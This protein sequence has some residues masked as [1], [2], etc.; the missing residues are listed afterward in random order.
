[1]G[2][3]WWGLWLFDSA[4][5][6]RLRGFLGCEWHFW[7][8]WI[9]GCFGCFWFFL[10]CRAFSSFSSLFFSSSSLF[11]SNFEFFLFFVL[12][13][14]GFCAKGLDLDLVSMSDPALGLQI[15]YDLAHYLFLFDLWIR[16]WRYIA[17]SR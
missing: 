2:G 5:V 1:M 13:A 15:H 10:G 14:Q 7:V 9:L 17:C 3:G 16:R 6:V 8:C 11:R 12:G 4:V